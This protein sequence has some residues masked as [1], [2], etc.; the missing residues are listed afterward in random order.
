MISFFAEGMP[1][2]TEESFEFR[3]V[4]QDDVKKYLQFI[5]WRLEAQAD[6]HREALNQLFNDLAYSLN[7][8]IRDL[9]AP[10]FVA[11]SGKSV[12]PPLFDSMEILGPDLTRARIRHALS[13]IGGAPKKQ[14]KNLEKEYRQ[15]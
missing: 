13:A 11:V 3:N 5:L 4:E 10:V 2:V 6:W 12:A 15:I 8:K 1:E 7:V 9:L 14:A